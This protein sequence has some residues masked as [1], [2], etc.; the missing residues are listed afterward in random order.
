MHCEF[1]PPYP[2]WSQRSYECAAVAGV[3][4]VVVDVCVAT[5]VGDPL[6]AAAQAAAADPVAI[7]NFIPS[8]VFNNQIDVELHF[9]AL[10]RLKIMICF[11]LAEL[12]E[13]GVTNCQI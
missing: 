6:D 10:R 1:S 11:A 5:P 12:S 9:E 4:L 7:I 8:I 3:N 13:T 2:S